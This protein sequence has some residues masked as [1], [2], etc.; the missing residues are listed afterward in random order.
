[1][2]LKNIKMEEKKIF[3]LDTCVILYDHTAYKNFGNNDVVIPIGVLEELD[4]FK[5]G[6][7]AINFEAREF[8]RI[9]DRLATQPLN[10]WIPIGLDGCGN[11]TVCFKQHDAKLD[12]EEIFQE[13]KTDHRILNVAMYYEEQFP[14][15]EVI[16]V[17][18]D[19][20]LRVKAKSLGLAAEDYKTGSVKNISS[21]YTG[22]YCVTGVDEAI[23]DELYKERKI[24]SSRLT[25]YEGYPNDGYVNNAYFIIKNGSKSALGTYSPKDGYIYLIE[26]SNVMNIKPRNSEQIFGI[27]AILNPDVKIVTIQGSAGTGKTLISMAAAIAQKK[28]F[29][30][31][32]V[33]RPIV[34][35]NN[36]D[37]GF[38]PGDI[39][40]KIAPYMDPI[41]D[42]LKFIKTQNAGDTKEIKKLD[43]LTENNKIVV[44]PLAFIRGRSLANIL[45]IVDE[46]QN[47]TPIEIK[48]II[49]RIGE[50]SKIIFTG[51]IRQID[52]PW[53]NSE[54]NGLSYMIDRLKGEDIYA[55]VTL[56]K[57]ER[58]KVATLAANKL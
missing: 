42:N 39:D 5:K 19:V 4:H 30:Q 56:E 21:L 54:S 16:L 26:K 1:M 57:G 24:S 38:L 58:S 32:Y 3:V 27:H 9:I 52:T 40:S 2:F 37:I 11:I 50:N 14:D 23:I 35:L 15:R 25:E 13:E 12:A 36:R 17:T 31:I 51:D 33:A 44:C 10:D 20:N 41:W 46:A 28:Q 53:L 6:N 29:H 49:T 8:T 47:L 22:K 55:H 45:F 43:E 7:E 48:T 34:P 18:K